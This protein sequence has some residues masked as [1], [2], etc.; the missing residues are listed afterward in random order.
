[1][2]AGDF[3]LQDLGTERVLGGGVPH[4]QELGLGKVRQILHLTD[5]ETTRLSFPGAAST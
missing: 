2:T 4:L 5:D 3:T 1:M